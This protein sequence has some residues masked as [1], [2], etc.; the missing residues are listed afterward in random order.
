MFTVACNPETLSCGQ[1]EILVSAEDPEMLYLAVTSQELGQYGVMG[2]NK[3]ELMNNYMA[4]LTS[5]NMLLGQPD[6]WFVYKGNMADAGVYKSASRY[7]AEENVTV[8]VVGFAPVTT[9][10]VEEGGEKM[11]FVTEAKLAT[12]IIEYVVPFLPYPTLTVPEAQLSNKV[13]AAAGEVV[14]DCVLTNALSD[15]TAVELQTEAA[16][17]HPT[18]ADNKLTIAYDANTTAVARRAKIAVMYGYY[19]NPFEVTVVQEKDPNAVAVTGIAY[20]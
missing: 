6:N 20:T 9:V 13:T 15:G 11:I 7:T 18:W 3:V 2:E 19:T 1:A 16:W 12:S 5:N 8:Y 4:L 10:E 14:V 17:V